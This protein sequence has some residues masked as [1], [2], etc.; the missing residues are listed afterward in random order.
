[1]K[2]ILIYTTLSFILLFAGCAK[3]LDVNH[4]P[5]NPSDSE[6]KYV[7][8]A[9]V[10]GVSSVFGGYWLNLGEIWSQH[11]TS[12][13]NAPQYQAE[14]SYSVTAGDYNYDSYGWQVL[15]YTGLNDLEWVKNRAKADGNWTYFLM[16]ETMQC[17]S[18]QVLA[19]FFGN[20]P[21]SQ[22]LQGVPAVFDPGEQVYD[23]LIS[24]LDYAL[25][26]DLT[27]TTAEDPAEADIVFQGDMTR[28]RMFANTLK[29]KI[30]LRERFARP[31]VAKAGIIAMYNAGVQF[32]DVDASMLSGNF[33]DF[34]GRS[35]YIFELEFRG[36]NTNMKASRTT[37]DYLLGQSGETR[38]DFLFEPGSAG[39][40][41][42]YQGDFRNVYSN[43]D[44]RA[45]LSSPLVSP[46]Q[47]VFFISKAESYFLQ[48]EACML[49]WGTGDDEILY[50]QGIDAHF[51]RIGAG[52]DG[53]SI[54]ADGVYA[55]YPFP[56]VTGED[57]SPE[58]EKNLEA[59]IVQKWISMVNIQGMEAFFEHNRTGYPRESIL[60]PGDADFATDYVKGEFTV[61]VTG[62]LSPP[63]I[64]PKRLL[65]PSSEQ[66]TNP[67]TPSVVALNIPIWWD[68][69]DYQSVYTSK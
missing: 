30:F 62:V 25:S 50:H 55:D 9:A 58:T 10:E 3:F 69:R 1:M 28:W 57:Y 20:I 15:Y 26:K 52:D 39:H 60:K 22:A 65:Y 12:A 35:N 48:A 64:F 14:D 7:F 67:N 49:G 23:T 40:K 32:L 59:I 56:L 66:S 68:V 27:V 17:Y 34:A 46:I 36:G 6:V 38:T 43:V 33:E 21:M 45:L 11:W 47:P 4:D 8:P 51:Q 13:S 37:L 53:S 41:G 5:N 44:D 24:R 63:V 16:A 29:L 54:Y 19:D 42:M 18:Y 31:D 2:K 61:S